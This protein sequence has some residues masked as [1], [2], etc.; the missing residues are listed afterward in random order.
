M[1]DRLNEL[2][3]SGKALLLT[4]LVVLAPLAGWLGYQLGVALG[5]N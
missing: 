3:P 4:A 5:S 1:L 2:S